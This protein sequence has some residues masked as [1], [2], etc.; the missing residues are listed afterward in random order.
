MR[1]ATW[2]INGMNARLDFILH[3]LAA[4]SPDV[5]A[6]QELKMSDD[7]FPTE[8][9]AAAGYHA[10]THGQKSWNGVALLSK[11]P[12]EVLQRGLPGQ[13]DF[14]SRLITGRFG[15]LVVTSVYKHVCTHAE[16]LGSM[17]PEVA[18]RAGT[19][20]PTITALKKRTFCDQQLKKSCRL[21]LADSLVGSRLFFF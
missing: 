2:N 11:E 14:G 15:D 16:A 1:V 17:G 19:S 7:K 6:L 18:W 4:R 9:F 13:D 5:V 10:M 20:W 3:W 21:C 8:A 12:G